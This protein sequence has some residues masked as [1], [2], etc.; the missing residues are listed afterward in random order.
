MSDQVIPYDPELQILSA[1]ELG[2]VFEFSKLRAD[3]SD[4]FVEWSAPWRRESL[5][6]YL[7]IGWSMSCRDRKSGR[8]LGYILAQ[9]FL[10]VRRQTQTVW[11]EHVDGENGAILNELVDTV[12][13]VS[14]EKHMQRV[15]IGFDQKKVDLGLGEVIRLRNGRMIEDDILEF[16]TTKSN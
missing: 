12:I 10:F 16:P 2:D 9:P 15:L 7:K 11:I 14:R 3:A 4:P 8:L 1:H 13:R 6:H 5:E